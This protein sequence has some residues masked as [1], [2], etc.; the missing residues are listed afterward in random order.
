MFNLREIKENQ[1]IDKVIGVKDS[2]PFSLKDSD[3]IFDYQT[4]VVDIKN[5][6]Y[7]RNNLVYYFSYNIMY[8]FLR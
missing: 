1:I 4:F 7:V 2:K 6:N 3:I 5:Y 8:F